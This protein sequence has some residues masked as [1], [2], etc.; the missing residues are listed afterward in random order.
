MT[1]DNIIRMAQEADLWL[2]SD[3]RVAAVER[4]AAMVAAAEREAC[5]KACEELRDNLKH[6]AKEWAHADLWD[7]AE[8]CAAAIRTRGET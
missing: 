6:S 5:A 3:E 4:F 7:M 8:G 1:R 2:T